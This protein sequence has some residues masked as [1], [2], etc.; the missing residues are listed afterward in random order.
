ML[1]ASRSDRR[2]GDIPT[3]SMAD[4]AFL[5]LVFFLVTTIFDQERGLSLVL[6][7]ADRPQPVSPE[8]VLHLW[9]LEDGSVEVKQGESP[10]VQR[11]GAGDV[12]A[13]WRLAVN[14]EPDLIAAVKTAPGA[15]YGAMVDVLD[16]LQ[17]VGAERVNLGL[18]QR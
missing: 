12:A 7:E 15:R 9:V 13:I 6:P 18:L 17:T 2:R 10:Q 11:V 4:I 8:N 16:A 3:S 5:L 1:R 14:A